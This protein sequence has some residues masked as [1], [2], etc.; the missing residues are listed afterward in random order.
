MKT[1]VIDIT[2]YNTMH[3]KYNIYIFNN[4]SYKQ[5][6]HYFNDSQKSEKY[7]KDEKI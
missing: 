7:F 1:I 6:C 3:N 4:I 2:I 5:I